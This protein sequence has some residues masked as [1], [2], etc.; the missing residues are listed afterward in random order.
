MSLLGSMITAIGGLGAQSRALGHISDNVAN[1]QTVGYKRVDTNFISYVTTATERVHEPGAVVARPA[2]TNAVQG[3]LE[4]SSDPLALAIGGQG[5]FSVASRVG[6]ANGLPTFD[7]RQ[8]FTRAGNFRLDSDG[9]VVNGAGYYLQGWTVP[10]GSTGP[11]RTRLEPIRVNQQVFNPIATSTV[12]FGANLPAD[13][14]ASPLADPLTAADKVPI[15]ASQVSVYDQLGNQQKLNL[16]FSRY[17]S[18]DA[19][20]GATPTGPSNL[21][22]AQTWRLVISTGT[23]NLAAAQ[24]TFNSDGTIGSMADDSASLSG[25]PATTTLTASATPAA[26]ATTAPAMLTLSHD[27]GLGL[28]SIDLSLGSYNEARGVTQYADKEF[29]VRNLSQNGVPL[30]SYAGVRINDTGDVIISYDNGQTRSISRVPL[31]AFNDP[32][33]LQRLDGQAFMRT[34]ESGEARVTDASSNGVG[35]I[36]TGSI[37]R[38]NVDIADEF[39]K[40]IVAQRAYS[41]NTRV[42]TASDEML[43]DTIN[44]KR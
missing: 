3:T 33:K 30:G 8:F 35:K 26:P 25:A 44:M 11:D 2:S 28:Q 37:E 24:L 20:D 10:S 40:L 41:S 15:Y 9:Y 19:A 22:P 36:V 4:Q 21:L 23:T 18:Y 17:D 5:F 34:P 13:P 38:S 43:Q 12:E 7:E 31:V 39:T 32:E 16:T 14:P 1:S 6:T 27:F 29:T 42:V